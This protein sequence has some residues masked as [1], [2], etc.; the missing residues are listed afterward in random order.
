MQVCMEQMQDETG[1]VAH[2]STLKI[3]AEN[4]HVT[5][6]AV[7]AASDVHQPALPHAAAARP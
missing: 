1:N 2:N 4:G 7:R 3:S 5:A 6:T